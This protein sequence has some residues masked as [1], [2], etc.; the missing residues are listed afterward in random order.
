MNT[1]PIESDGDD[2]YVT[3]TD[4]LLD[5]LGWNVGDDLDWEIQT[6]GSIILSKHDQET[7]P[8]RLQRHFLS[9][10]QCATEVG[11]PVHDC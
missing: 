8:H 3:F 11:S 10:S 6:D 4:D 9:E 5:E 7:A 1:L 2:L